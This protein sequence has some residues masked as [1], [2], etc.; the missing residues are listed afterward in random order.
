M[1]KDKKGIMKMQTDPSASDEIK[2]AIGAKIQGIR[3]K[4]GQSASV[5]ASGLGITRE[6]LTHIENGRNNINA[7][8]LW[9]LACLFGCEIDNFFP[10]IPEGFSLSKVDLRLLAKEDLKA[11]EWAERLLNN[12][13]NKK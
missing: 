9:K 13:K 11:P 5:V 8:Q 12:S 4:L 7:V 1:S 10:S 2:K 3:N 6:A